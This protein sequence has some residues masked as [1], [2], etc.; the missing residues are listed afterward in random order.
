MKSKMS[1]P[2]P[3]EIVL[4]VDPGF[5]R[6]GLAIMKSE[7]NEI[8]LLF[9]ECFTTSPKETRQERLYAIGK[10]ISEVIKKWKPKTLA[11]ET[12]FFNTNTTSAI[13]VAEARGIIIYEGARARMNV[14]ECGPL[15]EQVAVTGRQTRPR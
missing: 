6:I 9:S 12:L 7:K 2:T 4:A 5:D 8:K 1:T 11:I 15:L 10:R 3:S 13:G 14:F